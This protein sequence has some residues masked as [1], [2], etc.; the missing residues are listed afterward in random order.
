MN[1]LNVIKIWSL[2]FAFVVGVLTVRYVFEALI[3]NAFHDWKIQRRFRAGEKGRSDRELLQ[4][5]R[6]MK[7]SEFEA[8]IADMF[9]RLG[10]KA[11]AV[12]QSHDGGIDVTAEKDG[13]I[14]Y[15]Q[16]KKFV[17]RQVTVGA[18]RDFYGAIA[19]KLAGGGQGYFITTNIFT[20]EA[21]RFAED[22]PIE[23][24]DG[25]KLIHYIRLTNKDNDSLV[26]KTKDENTET[27]K[28]PNCDGRLVVRSGKFGR[29][30]GC[31]NYPQCDYTR[32]I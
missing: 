10:Y 13:V 8:Y 5:M 18:M 16:C 11:K 27:E 4:W 14:N 17:T 29:F 9:S 26:S 24:I 2:L 32:K 3:P 15:I 25:T 22:K 6:Q 7:P 12:G 28:C 31:S 23:L 19:D 1:E 30:L 21:R 20:L